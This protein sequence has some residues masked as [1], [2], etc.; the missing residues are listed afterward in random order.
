[1]RDQ[2]E[3]RGKTPAMDWSIEGGAASNPGLEHPGK[4][5]SASSRA[6]RNGTSGGLRTE[7]ALDWNIRGR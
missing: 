6:P 3:Q 5:T 7:D 2:P 4:T 1:M